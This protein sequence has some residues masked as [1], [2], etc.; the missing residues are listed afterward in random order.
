MS[1]NIAL[2]GINA[3]Q[4]DL[5]V[6]ANNI[7][8]VNTVG[9][10]ESRALFADVYSSSIFTNSKTTVGQG[11]A[12][13]QVQQ[14]FSQGAFQSTNNALDLAID[15]NGFFATSANSQDLDVK[16]TRAGAFSLDAQG[17][18]VNP[19]G[20]YLRAFPVN[21][22]GSVSSVSLTSTRP[23]QI[24]TTAG[25]PQATGN[26]NVSVNLPASAQNLDPTLFDPA[27][28]STYTSATSTTVYDSQGNSYVTTTYYVKNDP[29]NAA[30][31]GTQNQW[32][33]FTT[34]TDSQGEKPL[35]FTNASPAV[36]TV[37]PAPAGHVG[38][39]ITFNASGGVQAINGGN[40]SPI[41]QDFTS[42]GIDIGGA[43]G[44][45]TL[46]FNFNNPTQYASDFEVN[47][48]TQ[49][50]ITVGRLT[51]I[52]IGPD[53][54]VAATYSNGQTNPL[55]KIAIIRVAN[56]QGLAPAGSTAWIPNSVS[57]GPIAGEADSGSFGKV[58]SG[59]LENS[60]VNL[61]TEL[62]DLITSQRNF[63]ANSR[64]LET[65]NTLSQTL[66]QIR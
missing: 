42:A 62:V 35:S 44:T 65:N 61:T 58:L 32:T 9:F 21:P 51:G 41:T 52:D 53:G 60:N 16:L 23:L 27:D 17:F 55:G 59:T 19:S 12:T 13:Q 18:M 39:T 54:L 56:E 43:D 45:Q 25:S 1:F 24:P 36:T 37:A 31:A 26:V 22:D 33:V 6:T 34:L 47:E 63:Q 50:G 20:D 3:A 29:A 8:N 4:K 48:L 66:L 57:G 11:V 10:K 64:A 49:D 14:L 5:D 2:S 7:S 38:A 46:Q 28:D 15:G 40:G 30:P